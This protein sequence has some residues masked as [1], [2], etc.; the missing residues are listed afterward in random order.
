MIP[1]L[2]FPGGTTTG[3]LVNAVSDTGGSDIVLWETDTAGCCGTAPTLT[4]VGQ[5]NTDPYTMP[6]DAQQKG[7][8][9]LIDTGDTELLG[10]VFRDQSGI[11]TAH[12]TG[13]NPGGDPTTRSCLRWYQL[14]VSGMS[15]LQSG[16]YGATGKYYYYPAIHADDSANATVVF[17]RSSSSEFVGIRYTGRL[18]T[19]PLN[20]LQNSA[21]LRSGQ[22]CYV[23]VDSKGRDRWG[24]YNGIA[25]D[26]S[27]GHM[28]L[29]SQYAFG[30]SST[31]G[32]NVWQTRAAEV[33]W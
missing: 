10:A 28:W 5:I 30:T 25:V 23:L 14:S 4:R 33:H 27:N 24:D 2:N 3:H 17:N 11:W 20:N 1:T 12:T 18:S 6:P 7:S 26:T 16:T 22:G 19:D 13:C 9:A 21:N 8:S 15:V 32:S 31:C 29:V